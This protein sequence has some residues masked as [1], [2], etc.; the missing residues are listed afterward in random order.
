MGMKRVDFRTLSQL[1]WELRDG[2]GSGGGVPQQGQA[3]RVWPVS[4]LL[5][6]SL[7]EWSVRPTAVSGP[8][9]AWAAGI[10]PGSQVHFV[11]MSCQKPKLVKH[12]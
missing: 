6:P 9:I 11:S 4:S 8:E 3:V 12:T 2:C 1:P 5:L 10:F 7:P